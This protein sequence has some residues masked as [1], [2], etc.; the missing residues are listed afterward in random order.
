MGSLF[1]M[2]PEQ[3]KGQ[4]TDA[5]SDLYS[6]GVSLYELVTGVRPFRA[7]SDYSLMAAHLEQPAKPPVEIR[8][9]VPAALNEIIMMA[10]AKEPA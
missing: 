7:D 6:L 1:Y 8:S 9:E 5:R 4:P 10:I 2:S 3:V